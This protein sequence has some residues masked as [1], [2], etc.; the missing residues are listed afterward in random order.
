MALRSLLLQ[1]EGAWQG[2]RQSC[3]RGTQ[4]TPS[5]LEGLDLGRTCTPNLKTFLAAVQV[6]GMSV[7]RLAITWRSSS[8]WRRAAFSSASES[9]AMMSRT[10]GMSSPSTG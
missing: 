10:P 4:G 9:R 5:G 6:Q 1:Q 2:C 7:E 8:R 3:E